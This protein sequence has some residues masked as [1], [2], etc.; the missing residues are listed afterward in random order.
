MYYVYILKSIRFNRYYIGSTSDIERRLTQHNK[1]AT[2]STKPYLPYSLVYSEPYATKQA[3]NKREWYLKHPAGYSEKLD[4]IRKSGGVAT[5]R[6]PL[7]VV[8]EKQTGS[9]A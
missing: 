5:Q 4:I 7:G 2:R 3:A 1:G 6:V 9:V 8:V